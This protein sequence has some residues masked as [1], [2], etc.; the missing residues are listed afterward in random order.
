MSSTAEFLTGLSSILAQA[1]GAA[2]GGGAGGGMGML[3]WMGLL[4]VGMW[5]LMI[6]PQ[7]KAQK[8]HQQLIDGLKKGDRVITKGGLYGKIAAVKKDRV[9]LII[10]ENTKVEL[11]KGSIGTVLGQNAEGKTQE[12]EV[13][14]IEEQQP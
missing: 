4:F 1:E 2:P 12:E 3:V 11:V 10:G 9:S 13:E 5:F 7:R 14:E 6:A 8:K